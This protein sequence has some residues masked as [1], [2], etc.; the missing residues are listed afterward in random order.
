VHGILLLQTGDV[1]EQRYLEPN[2]VLQTADCERGLNSAMKS[3]KD[4]FRNRLSKKVVNS[5]LMVSTQR[6][7]P[8]E[9]PFETTV[10]EWKD[11]RSRLIDVYIVLT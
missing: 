7:D 1:K 8:K 4:P 5:L 2:T 6:P 3:I 10:R 11:M 9:F